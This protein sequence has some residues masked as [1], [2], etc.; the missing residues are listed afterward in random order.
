MV[1]I[2]RHEVSQ[3]QFASTMGTTAETIFTIGSANTNV[4]KINITDLKVTSGG[5]AAN[6]KIYPDNYTEAGEVQALDFHIAS[7]SSLDFSWEIPY[8]M[9]VTG[10]TGETRHIVSSADAVGVKFVISGYIE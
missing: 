3:F 7:S 5:V 4:R 1:N 6:F 9:I 2:G 10:S 8:K